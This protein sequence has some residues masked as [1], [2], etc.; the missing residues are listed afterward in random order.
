[1]AIPFIVCAVCFSAGATLAARWPPDLAGGRV[2]D[3]AF[4]AVCGLVGVAVAVAALNVYGIVRDME[5]SGFGGESRFVHRR[6]SRGVAARQRHHA[7]FGGNRL[8]ARAA[9]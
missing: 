5:S 4:L 3:L 7:G 9:R 6:R 1:M 2:G 8:S